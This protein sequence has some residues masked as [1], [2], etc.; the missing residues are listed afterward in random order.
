[1]IVQKKFPFLSCEIFGG[2]HSLHAPLTL[3]ESVAQL[4]DL[5]EVL[6]ISH[7]GRLGGIILVHFLVYNALVVRVPIGAL[8]NKSLNFLEGYLPCYDRKIDRVRVSYHIMLITC[9]KHGMVY[10]GPN[11]I[12]EHAG[13]TTT[14][15][16]PRYCHFVSLTA[17]Y[18]YNNYRT[19]QHQLFLV[20]FPIFF[21]PKVKY[22][23]YF[24]LVLGCAT[25]HL[26]IIDDEDDC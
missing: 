25:F 1:M 8:L 20:F 26:L 9:S 22:F 19:V 16:E 3:S 6:R 14:V 12:L 15:P 10:S 18:C 11:Q 23:S 7:W 17:T 4:D 24:S 21:S 5:F 13:S 2:C